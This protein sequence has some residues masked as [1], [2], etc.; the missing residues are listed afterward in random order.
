MRSCSEKLLKLPW[1]SHSYNNFSI[2]K[3][4]RWWVGPPLMQWSWFRLNKT[5]VDTKTCM[6]I[7]YPD[8]R[9]S[10]PKF[11]FR[12]SSFGHYITSD[13]GH[14]VKTMKISALTSC[15]ALQLQ[16]LTARRPTPFHIV[17]TSIFSPP[18]A[19]DPC[20]YIL[21]STRVFDQLT[22]WPVWVNWS[23]T[24]SALR[25]LCSMT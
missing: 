19:C 6:T 10:R 8:V 4:R 14:V 21:S 2:C 3:R 16:V 9:A 7:F 11:G 15:D 5:F 20:S 24:T 22:S 13:F 12:L 17:Y 1:P 18:S 25:A 23:Y